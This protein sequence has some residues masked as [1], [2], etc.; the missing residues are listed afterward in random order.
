MTARIHVGYDYFERKQHRRTVPIEWNEASLTNPHVG[1]FGTTGAGKTRWI[2][3]FCSAMPPSV[4]VDIFD[5]HDD[6]HVPGAE[7][8][9][10]S[11]AT[12]YGYNP[13]VINPDP[14]YGG[15]RR[16]I[17]MLSEAM[18]GSRSKL[19]DIQLGVLR[20]LLTDT[21]ALRGI[22]ADRPDTWFKT[23][24]TEDEAQRL[25]DAHDVDAL[26]GAYPHL[27][28]VV[29]IGKRKL[30]ALWLGMD[31]TSQGQAALGAFEEVSR[32]M[33]ALNSARKRVTQARFSV[34]EDLDA[35]QRRFDVL[36]T[37]AH[38][39][40][41]GYLDSIETGREFEE[42]IKYNSKDVLASVITRLENL[43]ER[44]IFN[45]NPPPFGD[46]RRRRYI[47][48]PLA[49][50]SHEL[51]MFVNFRLQAII[52]AEM[53]KGISEHIRRVV[54]LDECKLYLDEDP[55]APVNVIATEMRKFGLMLVMAGQSPAHC[56]DDFIKSAGTL[57]LL[58]LSNMD[59]D[60]AARKLG[61]DKKD[62]QYLR[63]QEVGMVRMLTKGDTPKFRRVGF[64]RDAA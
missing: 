40:F 49:Q 22:Y 53:Q 18:N 9:L 21:F 27:V 63:P 52:R 32:H 60:A 38:D 20:N 64:E 16:C 10:F 23:E 29:S 31:D 37:K 33:K 1:V 51:R 3:K 57:L 48:K 61:A 12:R 7:S 43:V 13:L 50:S 2:R 34:T 26:R 56:S 4:E 47:L 5:Y 6:I 62:L 8:V 58:H 25:R 35:L 14:H 19:G 45:P 59:W 11:E 46:A 17:Q 24:H 15:V 41:G 36:K 44:G 55:R 54:V 28:D 39:A 42:A 30:R